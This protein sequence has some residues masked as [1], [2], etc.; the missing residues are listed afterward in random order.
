MDDKTK[1]E[2][3]KLCSEFGMTATTA[4]NI[5]ARTVVRERRIPFAIQIS[6]SDD[7]SERSRQA[8]FELRKMAKES[9]LQGMTLDEINEEIKQTRES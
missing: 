5:F 4:I 1:K 8:F 2:F 3:D 9:G 7:V 6:K